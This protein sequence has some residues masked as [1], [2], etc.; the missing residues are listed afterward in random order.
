MSL[1]HVDVS[2][3]AGRVAVLD[4]TTGKWEACVRC[5]LQTLAVGPEY[6]AALAAEGQDW[7]LTCRRWR[8]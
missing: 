2:V 6:V 4:E 7:Q 5:M 8:G 3:P 1:K